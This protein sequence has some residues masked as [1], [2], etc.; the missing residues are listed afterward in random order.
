M[1]AQQVRPT[2][3]RRHGERIFHDPNSNG[4]RIADLI[5]GMGG[6]VR[7]VNVPHRRFRSPVAGLRQ[8]RRRNWTISAARNAMARQQACR[9]A[10]AAATS[11]GCPKASETC[12]DCHV[13]S[14]KFLA[15]TRRRPPMPSRPRRLPG[16][17]SPHNRQAPFLLGYLGFDR[18]RL[19]GAARADRQHLC[20]LP[21]QSGRV[22]AQAWRQRALR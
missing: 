18:A 15:M 19:P 7:P 9:R 13:P 12:W 14:Y 4:S 3:V 10:L 21:S 6:A 17:I 22:R 1:K 5:N 20:H 8:R 11:T 16:T 2:R